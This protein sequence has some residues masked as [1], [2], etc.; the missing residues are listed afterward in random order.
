MHGQW[1]KIAKV[2][3]LLGGMTLALTACQDSVP[4]EG[5]IKE[6]IP[7]DMRVIYVDSGFGEE[8]ITLD[9][10]EVNILKRQT[11][12]KDDTVYCT[13]VMSNDDYEYTA[14]WVLNY[15]YY[16]QGGWVLEGYTYNEQS[17]N[18]PI[19]I[20]LTGV[21]QEV[22]DS[23]MNCY[24]FD[25]FAL[26]EHVFEDESDG[27]YEYYHS[28]FDYEVEYSNTYC[29]Y[30]G[31]VIL[32]YYFQNDKN[33]GY[34]GYGDPQY[35]D[36]F[37]WNVE[38]VWETTELNNLK[39]AIQVGR[40]EDTVKISIDSIDIDNGF[41][42]VS[43][44]NTYFSKTWV[45]YSGE[46]SNYVEYATDGIV[47][48]DCYFDYGYDP[49]YNSADDFDDY[50]DHESRY[51][52]PCIKFSVAVPEEGTFYFSLRADRTV[53]QTVSRQYILQKS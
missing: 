35:S 10:T 33:Y 34:W 31:N 42:D 1:K 25:S 49:M 39:D 28:Y 11:N 43:V 29:S 22:A 37:Q 15:V 30:N 52:P 51:A 48:A 21:S 27:Y 2:L 46:N 23:E 7:E 24:Y 40:H 50:F 45:W 17:D 47:I 36:E 20:P 9:V 6:D 19:L 12:E 14:D 53:C 4:K 41:V 32:D 5:Q 16:D 38:G 18:S 44:S 13:V 26:K 3:I 8:T